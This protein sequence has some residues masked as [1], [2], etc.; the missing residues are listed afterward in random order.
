MTE[1]AVVFDMDGVIVNSNPYH[2]IALQQFAR[3]YSHE[4][5]EEE[6]KKKIYG[7]T[8]REWLTNL[9]GTLPD[10]QL[11]AYAEEK[12]ALYR[13]LFEKDIAP[14]K[15]LIGFL[16]LLDRHHIPRAIGTSAPRSNV[17][18]TLLRTATSKY[19]DIIV[20]DRSI[21][22]SKPHPE[23]YLKVAQQLGLPPNRCIVIEDSLSGVESG[24]AAGCSVIGITTTHSA[25]ELAHT[26]LVINDFDDLSLEVLTG[27]VR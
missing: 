12:E 13:Q 5:E 18:F 4:L 2:K 1:F 19:F 23:I 6:M 7:R 27:L 3:K 16:D 11:I 20:D 22:H 24:Q 15:G 26:N 8:N 14:V 17:D 9:F 21:T 10:E 25:A